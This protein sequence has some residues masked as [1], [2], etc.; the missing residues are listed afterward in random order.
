MNSSNLEYNNTDHSIEVYQ[1]EKLVTK[2]NWFSFITT[3]KPAPIY[4]SKEDL[5]LIRKKRGHVGSI[6]FE[7]INPEFMHNVPFTIKITSNEHEMFLVGVN[8]VQD[9]LKEIE[10]NKQYTI[11]ARAILGWRPK[12]TYYSWFRQE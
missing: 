12:E 11:I 3:R 10:L 2:A 5:D 7:N 1:D 9:D 6:I 8:F 4:V